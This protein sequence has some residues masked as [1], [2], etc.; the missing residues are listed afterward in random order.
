MAY[1]VS[2]FTPPDPLPVPP[3]TAKIAPQARRSAAHIA[4][5]ASGALA[6][7]P[8]LRAFLWF[9]SGGRATY[10]IRGYGYRAGL[11]GAEDTR[12]RSA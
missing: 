1:T 8:D 7:Y 5:T 6:T 10:N 4:G 2:T 9:Y 12:G 3:F 11:R